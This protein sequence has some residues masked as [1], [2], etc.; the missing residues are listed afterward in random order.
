MSRR[1]SSRSSSRRPASSK[2]VHGRVSAH[3]DG[4][5]FVTPDGGGED[6]FLPQTQM[7]TAMHGDYISVW[8]NA[9]GW[10]GK[11]S[12]M[13]HEILERN[14]QTVVGRLKQA[15]GHG[16]IIVPE[17]PRIRHDF[18]ATKGMRAN[19]GDFVV[20]DI[21]VF[22]E[23]GHPGKAQVSRILGKAEQNMDVD[24]A[25]LAFSLPN[26]WPQQVRE[27]LD[28]LSELE[29]ELPRR[30]LL[31]LPFVTIDGSD[32]KDFDDAVCARKGKQGW[33]LWVA[34][35][36]VA[37]YV[38]PGSALDV[39]ARKRATSVYFPNR[40]IPMLPPELSED[41]CSLRPDV[42][43]NTLVCEMQ[44]D[45]SGGLESSQFYPARI[46]SHARLTYSEVDQAVFQEKPAAQQRL[47]ELLPALENLTALYRLLHTRRQQRGALDFN[48]T[49]CYF[50][51]DAQGQIKSI[52][53][54]VRLESH[55]LIEECMILA[56]VATAERLHRQKQHGLY[57]IHDKPQQEKLMTLRALAASLG[58]P[59][60]DRD[61]VTP[62]DCADLLLKVQGTEQQA[63]VEQA[64]LRS[65]SQSVYSPDNIGHFGLALERYTHFTSPI[66]R[67]PDLAVHRAICR[68]L[69]GGEHS[70]AAPSH[71][72]MTTLGEHCSMAERRAD[73][74][75]WD[76]QA[77]CKC[78]IAEK[79]VGKHF[80]GTVATVTQFG[81]F[82]ALD[83]LFMDGLL[84][85]KQMGDDY[86]AYKPDT[87]QLQGERTGKTWK[88]GDRIEVTLREVS[89]R[90]RRIVLVPK[91]GR[92]GRR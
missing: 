50:K 62:R 7:H 2:P 74:A 58:L 42:E 36:D 10:K 26:T 64:V 12:G 53:P 81:M 11:S 4:Y 84:H 91:N 55:R 75:V 45:S 86:Y 25:I 72:D 1:S 41:L 6:I 28:H 33:T 9:A 35:A 47:G 83:G 49:E 29:D 34:I 61:P 14:Y 32:A 17:D 71:T 8:P 56:N 66:R 46:R 70:G 54:V 21:T 22:P 90:E 77:A 27:E 30:D 80:D 3:R 92:Q 20:A 89:L 24:L 78:R 85:I 65:Q 51:F 39:E 76:V 44:L 18:Q 13:F 68:T 19:N 40:V 88:V 48:S 73:E 69:E 87:Q 60:P 37:H 5:G 16:A 59:F 63:L 82:V 57:R 67:Y 31:D 23:Q 15:G 79:H 38:R 43:R 52:H